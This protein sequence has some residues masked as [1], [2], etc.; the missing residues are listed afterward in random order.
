MSSQGLSLAAPHSHGPETLSEKSVE[1]EDVDSATSSFMERGSADD[2]DGSSANVRHALEDCCLRE[3]VNV[4]KGQLVESNHRV[5]TLQQE[6]AALRNTL[7]AAEMDAKR[8]R[9]ENISKEEKVFRFYTGVSVTTFRDVLNIIRDSMEGAAYSTSSSA[10]PTELGRP[11]GRS[12]LSAEDELFMVMCK[13][14]HDFPESDLASRFSISQSAVSRLF[15]PW[16]L[17]L[18]YTFGEIDIWPTQEFVRSCLPASFKNFKST[19]VIIDATEFP[20]EK[21][22]NPDVQCATWSLL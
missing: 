5:E 17:C 9:Y 20:I 7:E 12:A 18:S 21:L 3:Q 4:L 11:R 1:R 16:V 2:P 6:N 15:R 14:R 10:A 19:R 13:L 22:A 8:F